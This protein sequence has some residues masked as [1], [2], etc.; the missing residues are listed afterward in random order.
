[1]LKTAA[2]PMFQAV[3]TAATHAA[4][5]GVANAARHQASGQ[6]GGLGRK[7]GG[8]IAGRT[9]NPLMMTMKSQGADF[10]GSIAGNAAS[11][12]TGVKPSQAGKPSLG[13]T[14]GNV[15]FKAKDL[16]SV[17]AAL[18]KQAPAGA[19]TQALGGYKNPFL[20]A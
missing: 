3:K 8:H 11:N 13:G 16:P 14:L 5:G 15:A 17:Q 10:A 12:L 19:V 2:R 6:L 18:Q 4:E 9:A 1:M 20:D 7:A